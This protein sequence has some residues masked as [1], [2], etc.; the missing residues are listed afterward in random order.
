MGSFLEK[1]LD[2]P[3]RGFFDVNIE[4]VTKGE[5]FA[6]DKVTKCLILTEPSDEAPKCHLRVL[7]ADCI[8]KVISTI[9]PEEFVAAKLPHV[10]INKCLDREAKAIQAAEL[11]AARKGHG[12]TKEAQ[13]IFDALSKTMPCKWRGKTIVVLG[14]VSI[15]EPYDLSTVQSEHSE[16]GAAIVDRVKKVLDAERKRMN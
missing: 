16:T 2:L 13:Q 11:D 9:V 12:V 10:D 6:N 7:K 1:C 8:K 5:V 3:C 14:E 4:K 15:R